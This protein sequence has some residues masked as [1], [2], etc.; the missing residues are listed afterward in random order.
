M[1]EHFVSTYQQVGAFTVQS[2][3]GKLIKNGG[4]VVSYFLTPSGHILHLTLGPVSPQELLQDAKWAT[5][6]YEKAQ[7]LPESQRANYFQLAHQL[8]S[9]TETTSFGS[10]LVTALFTKTTTPQPEYF[11]HAYDLSVS[12]TKSADA[13]RT[14]CFL[15]QAQ[16][17]PL[18][19]LYVYVFEQLL[20]QNVSPVHQQLDRVYQHIADAAQKN[21]PVLFVFN[22]GKAPGRTRNPILAIQHRLINEF[23][24]LHVQPNERPALS[25]ITNLP[26]IQRNCPMPMLVMRSEEGKLECMR[27][28]NGNSTTEPGETT[29]PMPRGVATNI[30]L[31]QSL[32]EY[33]KRS[34][35]RN[36]DLIRVHRLLKKVDIASARGLHN[37]MANGRERQETEQSKLNA[38]KQTDQTAQKIAS[39]D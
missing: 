22:G 16:P 18:D 2:H 27:I 24:V 20:G 31:A 19:R 32:A 35:P 9:R 36:A 39:V 34:P 8:A 14:H 5:A 1:S 4:D 12:T 3:N 21:R 30:S 38:P 7:A 10:K 15:S 29:Q 23:H 26:P 11:K 6:V 28:I 13:R 37:V 17:Q 25:Q 33:Y